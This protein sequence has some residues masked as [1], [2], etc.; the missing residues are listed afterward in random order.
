MT[1][2]KNTINYFTQKKAFAFHKANTRE[3]ISKFCV[4]G[5]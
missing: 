1:D 3:V 4:Q 2:A 5:T